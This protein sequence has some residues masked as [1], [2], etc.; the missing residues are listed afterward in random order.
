[1]RR[2]RIGDGGLGSVVIAEVVRGRVI[3]V[4]LVKGKSINEPSV[5]GL[6]RRP[7]VEDPN[8]LGVR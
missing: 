3:L 6:W 1:L 4:L 7:E 8:D 5:S 2:L